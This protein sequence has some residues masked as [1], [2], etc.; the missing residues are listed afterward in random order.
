MARQFGHEKIDLART[1]RLLSDLEP[2]RYCWLVIEL[3]HQF[4]CSERA[5]KDAISI[6]RRGG[7][8]EP[9]EPDPAPDSR[10]DHSPAPAGR[11]GYRVSGRGQALLEHPHGAAL[12]RVARKLFTTCPSPAVLRY[13]RTIEANEGLDEALRRI[14]DL[15]FSHQ[16]TLTSRLFRA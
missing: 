1:L 2:I 14:E 4:D 9:F 12:L 13:Q 15:T 8:I 10:V 11:R 3:S 7:W 6:L 16:D 5:A